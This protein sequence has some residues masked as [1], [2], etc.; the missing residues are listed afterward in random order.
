MDVILSAIREDLGEEER[1]GEGIR[2]RGGEGER[3]G[4]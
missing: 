4:G 1:S 2:D 3:M